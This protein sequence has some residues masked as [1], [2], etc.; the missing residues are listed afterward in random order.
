MKRVALWRSCFSTEATD[1]A[2]AH[3]TLLFCQEQRVVLPELTRIL[4]RAG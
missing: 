3:K 4:P 2:D 1:D